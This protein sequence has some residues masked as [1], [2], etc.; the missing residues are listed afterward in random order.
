MAWLPDYDA[1]LSVHQELVQMFQDEEDPISP[2]G[3]KSEDLLRSALGR[4]L[5]AIGSTEKYPNIDAK[6]GALF[7]SLTK[8]H[9]FHN[10][11]KRTAVVTLITTLHR[12]DLR[13][14]QTV[15]DDDIFDLAMRVTDDRFPEDTSG[16]DPDAAVA[17][18]AKWVR[19]NTERS[20]KQAPPMKI[21]EFLNCCKK[22]GAQVK[23]SKGSWVIA[24]NSSS[25]RV[26]MSTP[27]ISGPVVRKYLKGLRLDLSGSGL[28]IEEFQD[29]A[30]DERVQIR[31]FMQALRRLAKT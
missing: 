1:T 27:S 11:N 29:G 9:P 25:I 15:S 8:N 2:S 21:G 16:H 22:A 4:P 30:A 5:T 3:V 28:D 14:K 26:S 18:L 17:A 19:S 24:S 31:R 13:L 6:V 20:S 10:G 7:H 23:K 12:N